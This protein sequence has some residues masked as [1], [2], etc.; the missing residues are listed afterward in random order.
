[1]KI[2]TLK[3]QIIL[4]TSVPVVV[5]SIIFSFL[6]QDKSKIVLEMVHLKADVDYVMQASILAHEIQKERGL[7][8]TYQ[9]KRKEF[10]LKQ[11]IQQHI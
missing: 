7:S 9:G 4:L 8:S 6:L 2:L 5:I 1:M 11:L 3:Q 10:V